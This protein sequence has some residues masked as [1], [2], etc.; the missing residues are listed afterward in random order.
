MAK[1][2]LK[3]LALV[4]I[5]VT[6]AICKNSAWLLKKN[7][8]RDYMQILE[9]SCHGLVWFVLVLIS[10][11]IFW[12]KH[13]FK[14]QMNLLMSILLDVIV[15][16]LLKSKYRRMRPAGNIPSFFE[17]GPDSYSF[18]SGHVSRAFMLSFI[19]NHLN[20]ANDFIDTLC[21]VLLLA[22]CI[23]L[24][25]SRILLRKHFLFDVFAGMVLGIVEGWLIVKFL[26]LSDSTALY[27]VEWLT[28]SKFYGPDDDD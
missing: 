26:W 12:L 22:W 20:D 17:T 13:L 1:T 2:V 28:S 27:L 9:Y 18:P 4:D 21:S 5:S 6:N 7:N 15:V 8:F 25:Y 14:I 10:I 24:A 19:F 11:W 23:A 3:N 16:A